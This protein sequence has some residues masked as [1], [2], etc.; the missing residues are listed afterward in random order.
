MKILAYNRWSARIK[1]KSRR[2]PDALCNSPR[3]CILRIRSKVEEIVHALCDDSSTRKGEKEK[4][5]NVV[6]NCLAER[7]RSWSQFRTFSSRRRRWC[8]GLLY[9]LQTF[10]FEDSCLSPLVH[11]MSS[12]KKR[13]ILSYPLQMISLPYYAKSIFHHGNSTKFHRQKQQQHQ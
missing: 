6:L 2:R 4:H 10:F 9:R 7:M 8:E 11:E 3:C 5:T 12:E 1:C 13:T